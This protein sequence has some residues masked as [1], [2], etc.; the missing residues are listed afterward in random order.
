MSWDFVRLFNIAEAGYWS[1][2]GI[3]L[4]IACR[5]RPAPI[6]R[7]AFALCVVL[8]IF[9]LSDAIEVVTGAWWKPWWLAVMKTLCVF[10]IGSLGWR[11]WT[12][13][14]VHQQALS[15]GSVQASDGPES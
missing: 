11:L 1:V 12:Q 9:G 6:A 15:T 7:T 10:G 14:K 3:A 8:L 4:A 2:L 13:M 5:W